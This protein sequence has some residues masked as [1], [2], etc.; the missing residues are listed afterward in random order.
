MKIDA[1]TQKAIDTIKNPGGGVTL[2]AHGFEAEGP[3]WIVVSSSNIEA[4]AYNCDTKTL[5]VAFKGGAYKSN[6]WR[7]LDV[8]IE[9]FARFITAPSVGS[10]FQKNI[11]PIAKAEKI[12][13]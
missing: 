8:E 6:I 12:E 7:Y 5:H 2:V 11:K 9:T 1:K 10:F 4:V 3:R 13:S